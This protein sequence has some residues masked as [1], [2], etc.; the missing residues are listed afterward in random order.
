MMASPQWCNKYIYLSKKLKYD[1]FLTVWNTRAK[2]ISL[3]IELFVNRKL[4][5]F[6]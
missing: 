5:L 3:S 4:Q 1:V 2:M 6:Y